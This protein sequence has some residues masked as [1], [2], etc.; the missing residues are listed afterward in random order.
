[1]LENPFILIPVL[2]LKNFAFLPLKKQDYRNIY[3]RAGGAPNPVKVPL[4][5]PPIHPRERDS[6]WRCASKS[7]PVAGS[8]GLLSAIMQ[9]RLPSGWWGSSCAHAPSL[10]G[11]TISLAAAGVCGAMR[12]CWKGRRRRRKLKSRDESRGNRGSTICI[13]KLTCLRIIWSRIILC[14]SF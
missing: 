2:A 11:D 13:K 12:I 7:N 6:Q 4:G 1:M 3:H 5:A 9:A 10:S 8:L 14:A